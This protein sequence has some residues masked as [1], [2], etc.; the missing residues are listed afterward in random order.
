MYNEKLKPMLEDIENKETH[1]AGGSVVGIVL[2]CTNSLIE[3]ICNLTIGKQKYIDVEEEVKQ[4]LQEAEKLKQKN[5]QSIDKDKEVLEE[6]LIRY[7]NRKE[8]SKEYE[9]ANKKAVEFCL[10]VMKD[11]MKTLEL[12]DKISKYGNKMLSSDF[13]ICKY[14]AIASVK[15]SIVNIE[16]NLE[17]IQ[18]EEFKKEKKEEY[19]AL[20][21]ELN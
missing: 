13:K 6:I 4:I 10:E 18:D 8:K 17:S 5:L 3:Y 16:I 2:A 14:Y 21:K 19:C 15:A 9:E 1:I 7:K 12:T 20:R 11:A